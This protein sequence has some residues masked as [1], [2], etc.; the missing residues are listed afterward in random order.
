MT[1]AIDRLLLVE[2]SEPLGRQVVAALTGAGYDTHWIRDGDEALATL[3]DG[4]SLV[5][6]DVMLPGA[7]GFDIL[8]NWR[9]QG[10]STPVLI[11]SARTDSRDR[12]RAL[13][14]GAC[15]YLTKPFWPQELLERV[16]A[17]LG[18]HEPPA[19]GVISIGDL[20][21]DVAGGVA[22][23]HGDPLP[24]SRDEFDLLSTLARRRGSAVSHAS[25]FDQLTAPAGGSPAA[26]VDR[27]IAELHAKLGGIGARIKK[28]WGV[29]YRL[30]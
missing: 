17:H 8:A 28:V 23:L 1:A 24:L 25:L 21:I 20:L 29:G 2:D 16:A 14:L 18:F 15:G 3:I 19:P 11:A 10:V 7:S 26:A 5:I 4:Y 6:L 12:L 13:D 30:D 22:R 9:R 27:A